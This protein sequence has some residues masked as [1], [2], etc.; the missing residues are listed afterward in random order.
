MSAMNRRA[1]P[2]LSK[3]PAAADRREDLRGALLYTMPGRAIVIGLAIKLTVFLVGLAIGRVPAFFTVVDTVAGLA[4]AAG[5]VYFAFRVL[6][7]AKRRLLWRVRR[8]LIVSYMFIGF[9]PA[10]LLVAFSLLCAFLLF[11]NFSSYL[12]QSRLRAL[13]EQARFL[14]QS[15]ALEIQRAGGRDVANILTRRQAA[16][17][18]QYPGASMAVV[19]FDR[20]C[21]TPLAPA[22]SI[23]QTSDFR[24]QTSGP[25]THVNPA[26]AVPAWIDCSGFAGVLAYS[27]SRDPGGSAPETHLLVRGVA[28]PDSRRPAYAVVADLLV[29]DSVREQVRRETGVQLRSVASAPPQDVK[30]A[31]PLTGRDGGDE[32]TP[33]ALAAPGVLSRLRSPME[34]RD[35]STGATGTLMMTTALDVPELYDRISAAEGSIGRTFGQG[36]LLVLFVIGVLFLVIEAMA[37]VAG[38]ALAKSLTGSVHE[39][40]VGTERVRR[41]DFTHKIAVRSEDQLGELAQSFNSM[42]ASIEDLLRQAAEK[43]R[44]E[45]ELRIAHEIQMSLLPQG[46]LV[47]AGLS[48]TALCVPAREVGG[49]YYDF[50]PLGDQRVGVLIADVSGKGTSAA[51]YMAELKGL[52][53]SLSEIHASP[54]ALLVA[55][56][57]IIAHH[58]DARSFITMTYAV[59]DLRA[60]TMTYARAGHTPLIYVPGAPACG[61]TRQVQILA[62]DG[63]VVGLKLDNGEMFER[64]LVEETIALQPGDLYLLFTDGISEAMNSRDD[65]FG[66]TRLG[67]LVETHAH[68]PSEELRERMLREIAAFVG[69]APQHDDMTMILL[70]VDEVG[71]GAATISEELAEIAR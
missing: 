32:P 44:L 58:L 68:L 17:A 46:P 2:S 3:P 52:V 6:V 33:D 21:G 31:Q 60:R 45:E 4:V 1:E 14:A 12:V 9:V 10:F 5:L 39:L 55:A 42:T 56:N 67:H 43:K 25:W 49:D 50:L 8:K 11:Y 16:L 36:L 24:L 22:P 41:G 54:R 26:K 15:T 38:L 13:S 63:M 35:W 27:H 34:Y 47:M 40:F 37:L 64:H 57:R 62:P 51:L 29:N 71:V 30:D 18:A 48:V 70:K 53:L 19:P 61:A 28:F 20:A 66:E 59:I 7:L 69:D 65:L 23:A